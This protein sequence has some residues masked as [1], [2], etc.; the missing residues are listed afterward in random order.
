MAGRID[1]HIHALPPAYIA[2]VNAA[3]GDPSGFPSPEWSLEATLN[4]MD[5][6]GTAIGI[7]SVSAPGASI[8]GTGEDGRKL[9]RS[10]NNDLADQI[11]KSPA[12]Q[13]LGFFGVLPDW[14]DVDGTISEIDFLYQQQ[15]LCYG[16]T[17]FTSY[18]NKLLGDPAFKP[19]WEKLQ[20][21][22]ALVFLHPTGLEV[23]PKLIASVLPQPIV[24]Y[25]LAT[26][27]AAVDLVLS[28][29]LHA[30]PDVDVILSHAGGTLPFLASRV[31]TSLTIPAIANA[32]A[33]DYETAQAGFARFYYD[34]ALSGSPT[35]LG[36]LLDFADPS[37]ILFG[38]DFPYCPDSA[39]ELQV[40]SYEAFVAS[41]PR[42]SMIAPDVLRGN[43]MVLLKKHSQGNSPDWAHEVKKTAHGSKT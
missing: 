14:Q 1:T 28:G 3:G 39:I 26:T 6:T 9:A 11:T 33:V 15:K 36:G 5:N 16:V 7:L 31:L 37:H 38:S 8:A 43:S 34:T 41:H 27:R 32:V 24:D 2:A 23:T 30:F 17:V 20:A 10:L 12:G 42:G 19:I 29:T 25:P 40:H 18:G 35:Q 13:R 4:L 21:N 22:K